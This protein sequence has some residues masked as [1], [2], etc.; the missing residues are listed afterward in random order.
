MGRGK[1]ATGFWQVD[2]FF[3]L[4]KDSKEW[5]L[6]LLEGVKTHFG[7]KGVRNDGEK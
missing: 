4:M 7:K 3:F 5:E 1:L 6:D 2:S